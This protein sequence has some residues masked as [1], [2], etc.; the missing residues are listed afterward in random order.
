M[1][2]CPINYCNNNLKSMNN[3][4]QNL[5]CANGHIFHLEYGNDLESDTPCLLKCL[6]PGELKG[7]EFPVKCPSN[8]E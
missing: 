8:N 7:K 2:I 1:Y 3:S 4:D 6:Y 5:K